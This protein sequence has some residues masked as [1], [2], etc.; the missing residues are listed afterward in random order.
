MRW[1]AITGCA[2]LLSGAVGLALGAILRTLD[3]PP[4]EE[5]T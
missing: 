4:D 1:L 3:E 2:L 5:E